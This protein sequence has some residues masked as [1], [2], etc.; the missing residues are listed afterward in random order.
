MVPPGWK[1]LITWKFKGARFAD[2]GLDLRDLATLIGLRGLLVEFTK[3]VWR[4]EHPGE[5]LPP[6]FG[7][8]IELKLFEITGGSAVAEVYAQNEPPDPPSKQVAIPLVGASDPPRVVKAKKKR[9]RLDEA[10]RRVMESVKHMAD[11]TEPDFHIPD[12]TNAAIR[13]IAK[14]ANDDES[15]EIELPVQVTKG[16]ALA[17]TAPVKSASPQPH[18]PRKL[19]INSDKARELDALFEAYLDKQRAKEAEAV[20]VAGEDIEFIGDVVRVDLRDGKGALVQIGG[21]FVS[22]HFSEEHEEELTKALHEHKSTRIQ[23]KGRGTRHPSTKQ[24]ARVTHIYSV[25]CVARPLPQVQLDLRYGDPS[26]TSARARFIEALRQRMTTMTPQ[27]LGQLT[28]PQWQGPCE[29]MFEYLS[30]HDPQALL[31]MI[32]DGTLRPGHLTYAAEWAGKLVDSTSV[33]RTL[34]P[35]LQHKS[36][37]VREGAIYGL[38]RHMNDEIRQLIVNLAKDDSSEG[39]RDVAQSLLEEDA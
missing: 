35:L 15:F 38:A 26:T 10:A 39:V 1:P 32:D 13:L 16:P 18:T 17:R 31:Q 5:E 21:A 36:P 20:A 2:H 9:P 19:T 6:H 8:N 12:E 24:P 14:P 28:A 29:D 3:Q 33:R 37:L 11:G 34:L 22:V 27:H 25:Q 23:I 30:T 4:D 7:R